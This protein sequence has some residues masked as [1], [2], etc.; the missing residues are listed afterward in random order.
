MA[1]IASAQ[2]PMLDLEIGAA[3]AGAT[4]GA[5][6]DVP[7][8]IISDTLQPSALLFF[9]EFDEALLR[10]EE[11]LPGPAVPDDKI[12]DSRLL[13]GGD[14]DSA[15]V[16]MIVF[17][18]D[19][20]T[21]PDGVVFILRFEILSMGEDGVIPLIAIDASATTAGANIEEITVN[22]TDG[23]IDLTCNV[24]ALPTNIQASTNRTDGVRVTW[25]AV[26]GATEYR[27][28]RG[29][30]NAQSPDEA[31]PISPWFDGLAYLDTAAPAPI[32]S[33]AFGCT[34]APVNVRYF[35]QAREREFCLSPFGGPVSGSRALPQA[36]T[37]AA[38]LPTIPKA[39]LALMA[40]ALA[41]PTM[42]CRKS[43]STMS[44]SSTHTK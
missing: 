22:A 3:P 12:L 7:V 40:F 5:T 32:E 36:K 44:T 34:V 42:V 17:G 11:V 24:L 2:S 19:Q 28:Y 1:A 23:A 14:G 33:G 8:T 29:P 30:G 43:R 38:G 26:D 39:D 18:L 20:V 41:L 15:T 37:L 10:F 21:I 6:V 25:A 27:V 35:V 4:V 16:S 31:A 9:L 13:D